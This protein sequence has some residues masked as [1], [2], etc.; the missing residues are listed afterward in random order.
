MAT[1]PEMVRV[2]RELLENLLHCAA[3]SPSAPYR[4]LRALLTAP[5]EDVR[6]V[7]EEPVM[8]LECEKLWG[9]D[10]EYA[11][12]FVKPG[13]L[14]ECRQKGGTF[15]LYTRPQRSDEMVAD[16]LVAR[17][18][19]EFPDSETMLTVECFADLITEYL[20]GK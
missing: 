3:L 6:A 20:T 5:A 11:V 14:D 12:D 8:R 17:L 13:W 7:V 10:G 4:E 9:G 15:L 1:K 2:P 19:E 18:A 16:K